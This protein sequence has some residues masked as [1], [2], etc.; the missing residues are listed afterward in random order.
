MKPNN[1]S[2]SVLSDPAYRDKYREKF[3][4]AQKKGMDMVVYYDGTIALIENKI[5]MYPYGWHKKKRDFERI[6][7]GN[8]SRRKRKSHTLSE[9]SVVE[10]IDNSQVKYQ[11]EPEFA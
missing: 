4:E 3:L 5:T 7:F 8:E 11:K 6:K 10:K 2:N 1:C 9:G